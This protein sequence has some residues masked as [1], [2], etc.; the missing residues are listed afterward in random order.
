MCIRDRPDRWRGDT[1]ISFNTVFKT[2]YSEGDDIPN[3]ARP[4]D[5]NPYLA[6]RKKVWL[7]GV[8]PQLIACFRRQ[9][10]CLANFMPLPWGLNQ[11][12]GFTCDAATGIANPGLC[13]FPDLFFDQVRRWLSL[14]HI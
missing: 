12:R 7:T 14:I 3:G 6:A 11:W 9:Y 2:R 8:S 10:H 4:G 1:L 5:E 13:D